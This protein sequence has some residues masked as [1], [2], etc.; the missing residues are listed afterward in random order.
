MYFVRRNKEAKV[1]ER[2]FRLKSIWGKFNEKNKKVV[3][4]GTSDYSVIC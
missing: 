1:F 2:Q 4:D 3:K